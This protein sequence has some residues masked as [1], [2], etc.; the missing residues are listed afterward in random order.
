MNR[1]ADAILSVAAAC[2][3]SVALTLWALDHPK[4]AAAAQSIIVLLLIADN[5]I[6]RKRDK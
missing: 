5:V 3:M 6:L 4:G 1:W 2:I